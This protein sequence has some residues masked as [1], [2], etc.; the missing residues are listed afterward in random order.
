MP[1]P[2]DGEYNIVGASPNFISRARVVL[3][4][5]LVMDASDPGSEPRDYL[6]YTEAELR[7]CAD[8]PLRC[9][10][11]HATELRRPAWRVCSAPAGLTRRHGGLHGQGCRCT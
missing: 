4:H 10:C 5:S 1:H 2:A 9:G 11:G 8:G 7:D 3:A 6:G